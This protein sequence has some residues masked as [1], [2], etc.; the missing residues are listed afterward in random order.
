MSG[1]KSDELIRYFDAYGSSVIVSRN[2][3]LQKK[4][5][6]LVMNGSSSPTLKKSGLGV[7]RYGSLDVT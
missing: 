2:F 6:T 4:K 7:L 1:Q 3:D 5:D